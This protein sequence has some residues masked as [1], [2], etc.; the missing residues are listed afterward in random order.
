MFYN[1][2][3][4]LYKRGEGYFDD[5]RIWHEGEL[6]HI[7]TINCDVQ[8]YSKSLLMKD[9]GYAVECQN[10]A[11]INPD[12]DFELFNR[13]EYQDKQFKIVK[14]IEWDEYWELMLDAGGLNE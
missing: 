14:V 4:K 11:F 10:R 6:E 7:K 3:L 8:P 13:V 1:K 2:K 5:R 12:S 9:Y